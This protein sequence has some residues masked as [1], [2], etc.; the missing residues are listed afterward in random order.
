MEN[1]NINCPKN[2]WDF[3]I[4]TEPITVG[5]DTMYLIQQCMV[6]LYATVDIVLKSWTVLVVL[7]PLQP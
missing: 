4:K 3:R 1:L 7:H 2:N 6:A 5:A